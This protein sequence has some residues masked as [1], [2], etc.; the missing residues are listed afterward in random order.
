MR[1]DKIRIANWK[2]KKKCKNIYHSKKIGLR[3]ESGEES[4]KSVVRERK[5]DLNGRPALLETKRSE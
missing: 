1:L 4:A 3:A 2:K 5:R